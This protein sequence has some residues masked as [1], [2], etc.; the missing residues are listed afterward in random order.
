MKTSMLKTSLV[1]MSLVVTLSATAR[2][3]TLTIDKE[4][5]TDQVSIGANEVAEVISSFDS[6]YLNGDAPQFIMTITSKNHTFLITGANLSPGSP[7]FRGRIAIAGEAKVKV[8]YGRAPGPFSAFLTLQIT[9]ESFPPDKTLI[10]PA[11]SK[12]ANII[13]EQS[14][15]P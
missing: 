8:E 5:P 15:D 9:P 11:D 7:V 1:C 6:A 3:V 14:T 10:I 13:M 12:G 2:V 4:K